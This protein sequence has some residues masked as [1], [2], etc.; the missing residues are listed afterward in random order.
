MQQIG[1]EP[2]ILIV[3]DDDLATQI[4]RQ[5]LMRMGY[6]SKSF[7]S[8]QKAIDFLNSISVGSYPVAIISDI[9]MDD[10][11]GIDILAMTRSHPQLSNVPFIF[12][13]NVSEEVFA[14]LIQPYTCHAFLNKPIDAKK[15]KSIFENLKN[16]IAS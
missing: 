6:E 1:I 3:D 14:D 12:F 8:G 7:H 2:Y 10:G 13:S 16:Q 11:D 5:S 9:M 4:L 15:I